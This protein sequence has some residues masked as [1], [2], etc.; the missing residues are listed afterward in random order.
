MEDIDL[1]HEIYRHI[2][3]MVPTIV[4]MNEIRT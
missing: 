3:L 4:D 2:I 1:G